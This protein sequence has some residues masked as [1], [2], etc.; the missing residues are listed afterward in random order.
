MRKSVDKPF[1]VR[2]QYGKLKVVLDIEMVVVGGRNAQS[3]F[4][5]GNWPA[6]LP[7]PPVYLND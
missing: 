6:K 3:S 1:C 4:F 5:G 2:Q 7:Q